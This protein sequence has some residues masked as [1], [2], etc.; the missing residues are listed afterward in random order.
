MPQ[1]KSAAKRVRQNAVR[2]E[3]NRIHRSKVRTMIKRLRA[4]E[5]ADAAR[6]QLNDVKAYLDR[7]STKGIMHPNKVANYKRKLEKRVN[8][9]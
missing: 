9:L 4:T 8:T 5:D 6:T 1:H 3:Q 7:L 2:R